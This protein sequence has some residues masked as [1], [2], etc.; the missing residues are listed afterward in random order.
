MPSK[1]VITYNE[2]RQEFDQFFSQDDIGFR[3]KNIEL[4]SS[5]FSFIQLISESINIRLEEDGIHMCVMDSTH[6]SLVTCFIPREI[7]STYNVD[8]TTVRGLNLNH[9]NKVLSQVKITDELIMIFHDDTLDIT[10][11][12]SNHEKFYEVKMIDY[13][14]DEM[15]VEDEEDISILTF[16]SKYFGD[17]MRDLS[18]IGETLRVKILGEKKKISLKSSGEM[19]ELKIVLK[20][21]EIKY[22][23]LK[24]TSQEY[25]L[26]HF[27]T[28]VR[29]CSMSSRI[30]MRIKEDVP[31]RLS[32]PI[33][34]EGYI[35]YYLAPKMDED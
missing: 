1:M 31:L 29:S 19:T 9:I 30:E 25:S 7:F 22:E 11:I 26:K 23:N 6:V 16:N 3:T 2:D 28:F 21:G 35:R 5:I 8:T 15:Q 24:D 10:V 33:L 18:S 4:I 20:E 17:L 13:E 34:Q 27:M 32:F 14:E 12:N